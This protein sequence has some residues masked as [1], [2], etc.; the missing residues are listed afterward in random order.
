[1]KYGIKNLNFMTV[2]NHTALACS[3]SNVARWAH[4][5]SH[6]YSIC[7]PIQDVCQISKMIFHDFS[8]IFPD[9]FRNFQDLSIPKNHITLSFS[10]TIGI[11]W[12]MNWRVTSR[13][14]V[15]DYKYKLGK[16]FDARHGV[17]KR[18]QTWHR[19]I[20]ILIIWCHV[21]EHFLTPSL[22]SK[23]R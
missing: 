16:L 2:I 4:L 17:K 13:S 5:P 14:C 8:M 7:I 12:I 1:M 15:S 20:L 22:A 3:P 9:K 21:R 11:S 23:I 6:V 18:C 19:V 10:I